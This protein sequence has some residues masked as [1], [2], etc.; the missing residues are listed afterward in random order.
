MILLTIYGNIRY[1]EGTIPGLV[2]PLSMKVRAAL[3]GAPY[4]N[5]VV[6]ISET[7]ASVDVKGKAMDG[8]GLYFLAIVGENHLPAERKPVPSDASDLTRRL[9]P[10]GHVVQVKMDHFMPA[11]KPKRNKRKPKKPK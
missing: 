9:H 8:S 6:I 11:D 2:P 10:L 1:P 7:N 4:R 3:R 5:D